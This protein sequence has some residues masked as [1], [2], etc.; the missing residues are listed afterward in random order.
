MRE[1]PAATE[2]LLCGHKSGAQ[3]RPSA[4]PP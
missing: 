1:R 4:V 3:V 2:Q